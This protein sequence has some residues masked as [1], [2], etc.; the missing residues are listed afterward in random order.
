VET[1]TR[2][3]SI[4]IFVARWPP[5][6]LGGAELQAARTARELAARGHA[7]HV[8]TRRVGKQTL[9][10]APGVTLHTRAVIPLPGLRLIGEVLLGARQA[11]R[12]RTDV[13]LCYITL[14]S[15]LLGYAARRLSHTPCV[16]SLRSV[17]EA[18][19]RAGSWRARLRRFL[20][21]RADQVWVQSAGLVEI[22]RQAYEGVG[23]QASW[24]RIEPRLRVVAN[25]VEFRAPPPHES[26]PPRRFLFVGR[27]VPEKNLPVLLE[28]AC[29]LRDAE[30]QIVGDGP[31]RDELEQRARGT[32]VRF[33]GRRRPDE[34][35]GLLRD[36]RALVLCSKVEGMP[37][38]VLEALAHGRPVIATPVGAV[39]ELVQDAVNG[40]VVAVG[41]AP[42]LRD[43]ILRLSDDDTWRRLAAGARSSVERFAWPRIAADLEAALFELVSGARRS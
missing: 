11:R 34:V 38:S 1:T 12:Q 40:C 16:I 23:L 6:H 10:C 39:P 27:L 18:L 32:P 3:L 8:F 41:S 35:V 29:G 7:V 43:A 33:L 42:A 19:P 25:G 31:L 30:V 9:E 14:N 17:A 5:A 28:A 24:R 36:C 37:N 4:G 13:N 20:Y 26:L 21:E 22:M 15:G 2:A